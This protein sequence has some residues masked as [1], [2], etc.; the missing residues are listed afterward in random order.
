M[1]NISLPITG[2]IAQYEVDAQQFFHLTEF[3]WF[4]FFS[5]LL[6]IS[7]FHYIFWIRKHLIYVGPLTPTSSIVNYSL[8]SSIDADK[9]NITLK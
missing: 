1:A 3:I 2:K 4:V 7:L 5:R 8:Y 6:L 9:T